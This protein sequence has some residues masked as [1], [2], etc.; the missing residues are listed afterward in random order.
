[1]GILLSGPG[2]ERQLHVYPRERLDG[3]T[4]PVD[5]GPHPAA[6]RMFTEG[7]QP[8]IIVDELTPAP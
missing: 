2:E 8:A 1:M 5:R 3:C 7:V 6:Q 4:Q